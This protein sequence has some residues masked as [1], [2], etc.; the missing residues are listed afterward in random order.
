MSEPDC[1]IRLT[2]VTKMFPSG[3]RQHSLLRTIVARMSQGQARETFAALH[4]ID[5]EVKRGDR[6]GL[7]G[8]NGCGK[9]TL[10]RIVAGLHPPTSGTVE[11]N[12]ERTLLAGLG[13]GMIDELKVE[14]N[15]FLYGAMHGIARDELRERLDE[16]LEW[17][18][19]TDFRHAA[20]KTLST[21]MRSRLA[22]SVTRYFS[23]DIYLLDEALTA[24]DQLFREKC[25]EAF[26]SYEQSGRTMVIATHDFQFVERRCNKVLWLQRGKQM[27][28]GTPE[29]VLPLYRK[30]REVQ[31][32]SA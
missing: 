1:A 9:S 17:A 23:S 4:S 30:R 25:D 2:N 20:L 29:A 8:N 32:C 19:L 6:L 3:A 27:S 13:V 31:A 14:S 18:E 22:F 21:G 15:I 10:L 24:G 7:I 5:L 11:V 28:F 16:I 12:G 26:T